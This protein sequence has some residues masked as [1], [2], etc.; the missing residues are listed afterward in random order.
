MGPARRFLMAAILSVIFIACGGTQDPRSTGASPT[1]V[2]VDAGQAPRQRIRYEP[3]AKARY[4]YALAA[5]T[6]ES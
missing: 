6:R 4:R 3:V 5:S 1:V 2:L